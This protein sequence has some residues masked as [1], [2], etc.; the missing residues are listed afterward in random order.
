MQPHLGFATTHSDHLLPKEPPRAA[1]DTKVRLAPRALAR[2]A[3]FTRPTPVRF[4]GMTKISV[5]APLARSRRPTHFL[6]SLNGV[7]KRDDGSFGRA[8]HV[9]EQRPAARR[10]R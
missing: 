4:T 9:G 1:P 2:R 8:G 7:V 10:P 5:P 6:L 3:T